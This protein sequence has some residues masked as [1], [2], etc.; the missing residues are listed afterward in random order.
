V[1]PAYVTGT[2]VS[3]NARSP[4]NFHFKNIHSL[5]TRTLGDFTRRLSSAHS[6]IHSPSLRFTFP[7]SRR[8]LLHLPFSSPLSLP[9]PPRGRKVDMKTLVQER[10]DRFVCTAE[11]GPLVG[12]LL[13]VS[14]V[15]LASESRGPHNHPL[16]LKG[17]LRTTVTS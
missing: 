10:A 9:Q 14:A 2:E 8:K 13:L 16:L 1:R 17:Y 4:R 11:L 7:T 3:R 12:Q 15:V 6:G 5:N